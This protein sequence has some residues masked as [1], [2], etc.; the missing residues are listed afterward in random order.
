MGGKLL[1]T[2]HFNQAKSA[3]LVEFV[4]TFLLVLTVTLASANSGE[5]TPL[6]AGFMLMAII[7]AF[8]Y[9]SGG[10][11]NPAVTF[12]AYLCDR[13]PDL[14]PFPWYNALMY[15][16]AQLAGS[17]AA[18]VYMLFIVGFDFP[19]PQTAIDP[20]SIFRGFIAESVYTFVLA[21]VVLHVALSSQRHNEFY[22]FAIG[23]AVMSGALCVGT[24][25]G[26]AFNPA[27]ASGLI[28]VK[29]VVGQRCTPMAN[30][31]M[32]WAS[33]ATGALVAT[34][35][36]NSVQAAML[37]EKAAAKA[38]Q[39]AVVTTASLR[40]EEMRHHQEAVAHVR[41]QLEEHRPTPIRMPS[42][43]VAPASKTVD[44]KPAATTKPAGGAA[45]PSPL[46][47]DDTN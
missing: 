43:A 38:A 9:I 28:V 6:A 34:I 26:A 19:T 5:L 35:L 13:T 32:Y 24:L 30:L 33:E 47:V 22:G 37:E 12:A 2:L 4:G 23:M 18:G 11:F 17:G 20:M 3:V 44:T 29:C 21:S 39:P 27:V 8:G 15:M 14:P 25:T 10:H 45:A 1:E 46:D 36:F 31:W 40:D 7:F 41:A 16:I 42:P